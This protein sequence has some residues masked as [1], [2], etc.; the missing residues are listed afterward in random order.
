MCCGSKINYVENRSNSVLCSNCEKVQICPCCGEY[1]EGEGYIISSYEDPIC[2]TCYDYECENDDLT[3]EREYHGSLIELHFCLGFKEDGTPVF[4]D[5][6]I[7]TLDP[8]EYV[9]F[10][11]QRLFKENPKC[12]KS[13]SV[14]DSGI[15]YVTMDMIKD[16][17]WFKEVFRINSTYEELLDEYG[18]IPEDKEETR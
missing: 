7:F 8:S 11:Y 12:Y 10:E 2:W 5:E 14:W 4:Y 15:S 17:D 9:N 13:N 3:D 18:L 1:F 6:P 16:F